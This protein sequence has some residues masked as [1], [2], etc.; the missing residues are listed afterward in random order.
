MTRHKVRRP[1]IRVTICLIFHCNFV[2]WLAPDKEIINEVLSRGTAFTRLKI[3]N[4]CKEQYILND[5]NAPLWRGEYIIF[6]PSAKLL[7]FPAHNKFKT[8]NLNGIFQLPPP[9]PPPPRKKNYQVKKCCCWQWKP[10][11]ST[12]LLGLNVCLHL[13]QRF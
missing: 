11:H 2:C 7:F 1:D 9:P 12:L 3:F 10:E 4:I 5:C 13:H 8:L 6:L